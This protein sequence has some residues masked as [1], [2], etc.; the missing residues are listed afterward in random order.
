[1][2]AQPSAR[3]V[4]P[5][6]LLRVAGVGGVSGVPPRIPASRQFEL[7]QMCPEGSRDLGQTHPP[8]PRKQPRVQKR[9][10]QGQTSA[11]P[12][13]P[14][15]SQTPAVRRPKT[16]LSSLQVFSDGTLISV[17]C[18][19]KGF[20]EL[21]SSVNPFLRSSPGGCL[22]LLFDSDY[23]NTRRNSGFRGFYTEEG[24]AQ[25]PQNGV[26]WYLVIFLESGWG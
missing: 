20:A 5:L 7:E 15:R 4:L 14:R 6:G 18:G 22:T 3:P 8:G 12:R 26:L 23:S 17:L 2:R 19:T 1:M 21:Q 25:K 16:R 11:T 13:N 9:C 24:E 10:R